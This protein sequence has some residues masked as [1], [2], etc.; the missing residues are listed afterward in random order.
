MRYRS[1]R[2]FDLGPIGFLIVAN[3]IVFLAT[4]VRPQLIRLLGLQ[5]AS[6]LEMPWTMLTNLFV[7]AGMWHIFTNML[8]LYFFGSYLISLVG[9]KR[10]F[11]IYFLGGIAGNIVYLLLASPFSI[12]V[13]AS[14]AVFAVAGALTVMKPRL[15]VFIFPI[16]VPIHLWVAVI[17]GFVLLSFSPLVAWQAHLG[18]LVF[19]LI[20]GYFAQRKGYRFY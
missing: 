14:G 19:G 12:A 13:G 11:I 15:P 5:P 3:L 16:P 8:T 18:G 10:F 4:S 9:E 7:H 2:D 1:Y 20:T 17:G 6:F